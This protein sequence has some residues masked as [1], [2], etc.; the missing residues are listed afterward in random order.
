MFYGLKEYMNKDD[1]QTM[2]WLTSSSGVTC[3]KN[4]T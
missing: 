4:Y 2:K 1:Q 3:A